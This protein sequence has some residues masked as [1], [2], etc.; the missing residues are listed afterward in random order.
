MM[1]ACTF[2]KKQVCFEE[3]KTRDTGSEIIHKDEIME[4]RGCVLLAVRECTV[5][6]RHCECADSQEVKIILVRVECKTDSER[7][8]T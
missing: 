6:D 5:F 8:F 4:T 7:A 2:F 1:N 3:G